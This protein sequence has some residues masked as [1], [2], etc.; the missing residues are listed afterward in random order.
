VDGSVSSAG[1]MPVRLMGRGDEDMDYVSE[2]WGIGGP[3]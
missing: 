1:T 3:A 2:N